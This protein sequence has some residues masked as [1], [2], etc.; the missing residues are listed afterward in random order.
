VTF[1]TEGQLSY[2]GHLARYILQKRGEPSGSVLPEGLTRVR[3]Y[4][5]QE[6][7]LQNA[8]ITT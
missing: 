1:Y 3:I 7:I 4:L 2:A 8:R 6:K 5:V